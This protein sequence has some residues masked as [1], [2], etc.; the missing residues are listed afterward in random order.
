MSWA[1]NFVRDGFA[2][3]ALEQQDGIKAIQSLCLDYLRQYFQDAQ[4]D[5]ENYHQVVSSDEQH[6]GIQYQLF[7][8]LHASGL[9]QQVVEANLPLFRSIF[10]PDIDIQVKPYL[11]IARPQCPQDNI[12]FHWDTFYG[13]SAYEV[14]C[15]FPLT[16]NNAQGALQLAPGSQHWP[17]ASFE[18]QFAAEVG[19]G[20][21][22]N[23]MG[24]L[25]AP[26]IIKDLDYS[27]LTPV[28][29]EPGEMLMFSLGVLHGQEVNQD[30]ACRWSVDFRLKAAY[31]PVSKYLKEGYYRRLCAS[32]VSQVA[33]DYYRDKVTEASDLVC[34]A[35]PKFA[36]D[37]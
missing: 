23:Q 17:L 21:M 11:R 31:A 9:H 26:K 4:V 12:G 6:R 15:V 34:K 28:V 37:Q 7:E 19:K 13:N 20:S 36:V 22:A 5:L 8:R 29:I 27:K 30:T 16:H 35:L 33:Q 10:G 18:Q 25:Y 2:V 3:V 32:V 1:E 24:F 14:S